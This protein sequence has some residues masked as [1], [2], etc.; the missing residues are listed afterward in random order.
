M[1][2]GNTLKTPSSRGSPHI[3]FI[4]S[5]ES[6]F[7]LQGWTPHSFEQRLIP[8]LTIVRALCGQKK[9]G[10][11]L[12][13]DVVIGYYDTIES[14]RV[15]SDVEPGY[16]KKLLPDGPPELGEAWAE[17]QSDIESKIMPGLT[18]WWAY[19]CSSGPCKSSNFTPGNLQTSSPSSPPTPPTLA[20]SASSTPLPSRPQISIGSALPRPPSS[21]P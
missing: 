7:D 11:R 20:S 19:S 13:L 1:R 9:F 17:I 4:S 16:L 21:K 18:H 2:D 8:Q 15:L 12:T 6:S 5:S 10:S 3:Q 14:R